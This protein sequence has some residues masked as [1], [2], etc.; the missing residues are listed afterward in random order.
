MTL[1]EPT[2]HPLARI[3]DVSG[4]RTLVTG[5]ASGLGLAIAEAMLDCGARVTIADIDD[6]GLDAAAAR[7]GARD[8]RLTAA[9]LDITDRPAVAAF[10]SA[11]ADRD[12]GL[13]VAFVNAGI[14]LKSQREEGEL[15]GL[16]DAWDRVLDV[17]LNGTFAVLKACASVMR[18]KG[19]GRIIVTASTA[20]LRADPLC[21]NSYVASKAAVVNLTRQAALQLAP[22]GV[23]VNAIAPG[24]FHTGIGAAAGGARRTREETEAKWK[25]TIPLG[26]MGDPAEIRG[27]ALLL[28]SGAS[29][30]MTGGVYPVDGGALVNYAR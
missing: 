11:L 16:D 18:R 28:A 17:N 8:G 23:R 20:G 14:S 19:A 29:S 30:F 6:S 4:A 1:P 10:V 12:G 25:E 21:G 5:G 7:L 15:D 24:P 3:F 22:F 26:R 13:D 2:A 9:R 27:L